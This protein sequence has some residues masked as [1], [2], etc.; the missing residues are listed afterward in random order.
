MHQELELCLVSA[1]FDPNE[2]PY[3]PI[4][5]A[6][7]VFPIVLAIRHWEKQTGFVYT[8]LK[9]RATERLQFPGISPQLDGR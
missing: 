9:E 3:T 7:E 6:W 8:N 5:E 4:L 1:G 2:A